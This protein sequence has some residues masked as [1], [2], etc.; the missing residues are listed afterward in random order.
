MTSPELPTV[1]KKPTDYFGSNLAKLLSEKIDLVYSDFNSQDFVR[2]IQNACI[3][4]TLSQRVELIADDLK[5][6]LPASFTKATRILHKIL[7]PENPNE[8]G[9]FTD[10]YWL[11]PVAK[12]IEKYGLDKPTS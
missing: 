9:M 8:T 10:Y 12:F 7:G 1:I 2:H 11:L 6:Y 3:H 5:K 4:L